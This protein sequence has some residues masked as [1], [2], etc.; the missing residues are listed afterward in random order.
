MP[1]V[2]SGD[3]VADATQ[4]YG[5]DDTC[6]K[7]ADAVDD[8][9]GTVQ[10]RQDLVVDVWCELLVGCGFTGSGLAYWA[11]SRVRMG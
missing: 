6:E 5:G 3:G 2:R 8:Y 7:T 4:N 10:G 1:N 9:C 11:R